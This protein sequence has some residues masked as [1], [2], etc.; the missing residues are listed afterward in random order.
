MKNEKW[1]AMGIPLVEKKLKT[2][3]ATGLSRKAARSRVTRNA[4]SVFYLPRK[5][6]IRLLADLLSDFSLIILLLTALVSLFFEEGRQLGWMVLLLIVGNLGVAWWLYYR[7]QRT[8]E[9]INSVFCPSVRVIR[10]GKLFH[11][12]FRSVV[13]GDVILIE[14]G[15]IVCCDA[16]LISAE[17]LSVRM[18]TD[19]KTYLLLNKDANGYVDPG[20][21][22]ATKMVTMVHAGSVVEKGSA[23]A[24]VTAVGKY[25]YLG[26]MTGG[27]AFPFSQKIPVKIQKFQKYC[28]KINMIFLI[29][30]LPFSM[31]GLLFSQMTGGTVFL[32]SAFLTALSLAAT[33]MSQLICLLCRLFYVYQIRS[34]LKNSN[35][36]VIRS[37]AAFDKLADTDYIFLLDGAAVTDG[38]LHFSI[39]VCADG[40]V[41]N[42]SAMSATA[43]KL[44]ELVSVYYLAVT[45]TVTTGVSSAGNYLLGIQ[46][47]MI[48]SAIDKTALQIRC[49]ITSYLPGNMADIPET[50]VFREGGSSF[51]LHV[52]YTPHVLSNCGHVMIGGRKHPIGADG[53]KQLTKQ[54]KKYIDAQQTPLMFLLSSG[55]TEYCFVGFLVLKEGI[56]A[57][58]T[59]NITYMEKLGHQVISFVHHEVNVPHIPIQNFVLAEGASKHDF[60]RNHVPVTYQFGRFRTYFNLETEDILTLIQ[61]I[62]KQGKTVT[63]VG[64]TEKALEIAALSDCFVTCAPVHVKTSG[65]WDEEIG[66]MELAGQQYSISCV[67]VVKEKADILLPRPKAGKGGLASLATAITY[68]QK[69]CQNL[70][71]FFR[72]LMS[73]QLIRLLIVAVPMFFGKTILDARH[74]LFCSCVLDM[75]AFQIFMS[76]RSEGKKFSDF[77]SIPAEYSIKEYF[78]HDKPLW[79][80]ALASAGSAL[81]LPQILEWFSFAGLYHEKVELTFI[82]LILLHI[83]TLFV[84]YYGNDLQRIKKIY[85]NKYFLT[86]LL[87]SV[88]FLALCFF[89]DWFGEFFEIGSMLSL[90]YLVLA[91]FP[92]V[93]FVG[94]FY[95][96]SYMMLKKQNHKN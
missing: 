37:M 26:A 35:A 38:I 71:R 67:Q 19:Q 59:K 41:R 12:D 8:M 93:C 88:V 25:T 34:L 52:A 82:A 78:L 11:V 84:I 55:K 36:S 31:I 64:F 75:F 15:D 47:F 68:V 46:E 7:S 23:R 57:N 90:P 4:G 39:A 83:T 76:S 50:V 28:S 69:A 60:I 13:P 80:S 53:S 79:I 65:Y 61:H 81:V 95:W 72:Y 3:A 1:F 40:E 62:H 49:P 22:Q 24:I 70:S 14:A 20:E 73:T 66:T 85:Q 94:M 5:L 2:N 51:S 33:T 86:E 30:V 42:Y 6:P 43:K 32:S 58:W 56:A 63:V 54:W 27:I 89:W 91:I 92:S 96:L 44:C 9:S 21:H 17:N 77:R 87:V 10:N 48:Q 74:V 18:R 45:N 16:R 29:A